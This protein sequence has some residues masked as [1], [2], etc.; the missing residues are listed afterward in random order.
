M[1]YEDSGYFDYAQRYHWEYNNN[2]DATDIP[3]KTFY[4]QTGNTRTIEYFMRNNDDGNYMQFR[5][6]L[7]DDTQGEPTS[8]NNRLIAIGTGI[9]DI[10]FNNLP[11]HRIWMDKTS[12][13]LT[14]CSGQDTNAQ[15]INFDF[16]VTQ[17]D[18]NEDIDVNENGDKMPYF[19][20]SANEAI[21]NAYGGEY[22]FDELLNRFYRQSAFY[23]TDVGLNIWWNWASQYTGFVNNWYRNKLKANLATWEQGDD[24]YG[25]SGYMWSWPGNREWPMGDLYLTYDFHFL[26]TN[27]LF[28]QAVWNYYA[29]TGDDAFLGGQLQRLRDAMQY[30]LDWLGGGSEHIINGDNAYDS[31][32]GGIHNEDVGT[33][34]WDIMPFGGKD[35]YCS[36]DF[37][38]SLKAM[39]QIEYTLGNTTEGDSYSTMTEQA[40][41]AYNT[42]FW[43]T[44]TNRYVGAID[45][46]DNVHDYGFSFV[47]IEALAAGLGDSSKAGQIYNWL[48]SGDIY[49]KW[50][51]APRTN[52][53][54]TQNLWRIPNNN[55]YVWE[56]QL[57]DGG[58]NLYVSGYDVIARAKYIN[59]D[60]AYNRLKAVLARYSEPDKLTGGSP[61]IFNE[62]IQGGS[63]GAGSLGVMS[64]EF[65]E[66]GIAGSSFVY[67]FIGLEHEVDGLHIDPRIPTGMEYIGA[68]NINYRGMNLNF[69]IT[70]SAISIECTKNEDIADSYF[71]IGG[72]RRP[73]PAGTFT[74]EYDFVCEGD[75][76]GDNDV[77]GSDLAVFA[78]DF[79]RTDC[80][81]DCDGDFDFDGDVDGSD[82]AVFAADFGRTNCPH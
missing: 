63:D 8:G 50:N 52:V 64:H 20:T 67:A 60:D 59:A 65:P 53:A 48:G 51:F 25:H 4:S 34:Y 44:T 10:D 57:Q 46:L 39:S 62:T 76:D 30:Q 31:D 22:T 18:E 69:H 13:T 12:D 41:T 77:D 5:T 36:I 6:N 2:H 68:K 55:G 37:Y 61:T 58:A 73:F 79:G 45:W 81:G 47:N 42:A 7:W 43:S 80:S 71:L 27:A 54:T 38:K 23:Y 11:S 32:H 66:S 74:I 56:Q 14:L 29:W 82:L 72:E 75:F 9:F 70:G 15:T 17:F 28:I 78:A 49:N 26:N 16:E 3:F 33:N 24:G 1:P 19:Y 35:A 21:T 40:K